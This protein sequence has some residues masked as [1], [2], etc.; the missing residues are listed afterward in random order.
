M[1]LVYSYVRY[2]SKKQMKG[3]SLRRQVEDGEKWIREND[4]TLANTTLHDLGVSAF[5]GKNRHVGAL[6][7]FLD[8]IEQG[9]I[10]KGSIL[11]CENLDRI[12][13]EGI[14]AAG[15]L[16]K[17]IIKAGVD[18]ATLMPSPRV[19][20]RESLND[21]IGL[22]E[23]LLYFHNAYLESKKK[24]ERIGKN[25][26]EKRRRIAAGEV[27][28]GLRPSWLDF[29]N[30]HKS[31]TLNQGAAA[32]TFIFERTADG[33]GQRQIVRELQKDFP[34]I[35]R[36]K[37]WN[38]SFVQKV[39]GDRAVIGERQ[40]YRF[41]E[42]GERVPTGS[43]VASYYPA[44]I[45][46]PLWFRAQSQKRANRRK[47]GPNRQFTNLFTGLVTNVNDGYPM[48][49]QTSRLPSGGTSR[50]LVSYGHVRSVP[51]SDPVTVD[52][53]EFERHALYALSEIPPKDLISK[54][55]LSVVAESEQELRGISE[56]ITAT[57]NDLTDPKNL[58]IRPLLLDSLN[59]LEEKR[60][61]LE[62][63]LAVL[64]T[65]QNADHSLKETCSIEGMMENAK[66]DDLHALRTKL[67]SRICDL[68]ERI[69]VK[70]EKHYGRVFALCQISF[71]SATWTKRFF[72][73]VSKARSTILDRVPLE[74]DRNRLYFQ[75]MAKKLAEPAEMPE[76][77]TIP[78]T[79]RGAAD[80]WLAV[81][82]A[83]MAK[84]SYRVVPSKI[85]RFLQIIG[86]VQIDR[87]NAD[88]WGLWVRSLKMDVREGKLQFQTARIAY[89]RSREF[90]RWLIHHGKMT[91][92]PL[93]DAS[94]EKALK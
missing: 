64:R 11:L 12:S 61:T 52:Y 1:S 26:Q 17:K 16:F 77:T 83:E 67:R 39:L 78:A 86:D 80:L 14:D 65:S 68:V 50:R 25:W 58:K 87:M 69:L 40:N 89:S 76:I 22:I 55:S 24:S 30:K 84:D 56:T 72:L 51:G 19:Y 34:P 73:G 36:S 32:I 62:E 31:F 48:H 63:R 35:G 10:P 18:I 42:D 9:R 85:E 45:E 27:V 46:E 59:Q 15:D 6:S 5:K 57:Q 90:L 3:D 71:H 2:S 93:L 33:A 44:V 8:E 74:I 47:K 70:P 38:S 41:T 81:R 13:R 53:F 37:R 66:G 20:T 91:T 7:R 82:R 28:D 54:R 92:F 75:D 23:P 49:V 21:P 43:P 29:D 4:H 88:T 94:A 79:L 60:E